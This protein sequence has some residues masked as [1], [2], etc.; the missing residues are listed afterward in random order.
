MWRGVGGSAGLPTLAVP[1]GLRG[2][3]RTRRRAALLVL[4]LAAVAAFAAAGRDAVR[5]AGSEGELGC[6]PG[7]WLVEVLPAV[8]EPAGPPLLQVPAG[9]NKPRLG[10]VFQ[11]SVEKSPVVE[12]FE[13][14]EPPAAGLVLVATEYRSFGAGLPADAPPGARFVRLADRFVI[15]GLAVPVPRLVLRPMPWTE[16]RLLVAG[17]EYDLSGLA[18]PGTP[19]EIQV[20]RCVARI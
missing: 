18:E 5:A 10:I 17:V 8:T 12:W 7:Q 14:G 6:G 16:H 11:H 1:E 15:E 3:A 2:Q 20:V 4:M 9:C 13:P 19:L